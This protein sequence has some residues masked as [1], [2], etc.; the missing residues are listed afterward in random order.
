MTDT[1]PKR[2]R[3]KQERPDPLP[4]AVL[5]DMG[6]RWRIESTRAGVTQAALARA[7]QISRSGV[8]HWFTG[9]NAPSLTQIYRIGVA[10]PRLSLDYILFGKRELDPKVQDLA[11]RIAHMSE[12]QVEALHSVF[13]DHASNDRVADHYGKPK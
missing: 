7:A 2:K 5:E 9:K 10:H 3:A 4:A 13:G 6:S 1:P 11:T 12:D 8:N